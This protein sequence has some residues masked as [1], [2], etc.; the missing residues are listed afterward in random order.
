MKLL[1]HQE[2]RV[3]TPFPVQ[4]DNVDALTAAA[5]GSRENRGAAV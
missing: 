4:E 3:V 1:E 5:T 2:N